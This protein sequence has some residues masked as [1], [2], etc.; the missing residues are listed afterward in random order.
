MSE[1][2]LTDFSEVEKSV[3]E[4]AEKG[5][6]IT[7]TMNPEIRNKV[8]AEALNS[9]LMG[10]LSKEQTVNIEIFSDRLIVSV[11]KEYK[12]DDDGEVTIIKSELKKELIPKRI[13]VFS[14]MIVETVIDFWLKFGVT[15]FQ[16]I[17]NQWTFQIKMNKGFSQRQMDAYWR[18]ASY[19]GWNTEGRFFER[20]WLKF[21]QRD[22]PVDYGKT[23]GGK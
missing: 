20:D 19:D 16:A 22:R 6:D 11:A 9:V 1:R 8:V 12:Y 17:I 10:I 15:Y 3:R 7:I 21:N 4:I 18:N 2:E 5:Q 23:S 14:N 13:E